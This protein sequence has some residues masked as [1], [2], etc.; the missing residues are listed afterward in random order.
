MKNLI[1]SVL[2]LMAVLMSTRGKMHWLRMINSSWR[3]DR[4]VWFCSPIRNILFTL[5][6]AEEIYTQVGE[7]ITLKPPV[8]KDLQKHYWYWS[9][10]DV[11]LAWSHPLGRK[12]ITAGEQC[13]ELS[14]Y[15]INMFL[16][17]T[18]ET[19]QN[20]KW[21][22][23]CNY[24]HLIIALQLEKHPGTTVCPCLTT[25]HW[26]L[27][28]SNKNTSGFLSVNT[29]WILNLSSSH[30]LTCSNSVVRVKIRWHDQFSHV[31]FTLIRFHLKQ[32]LLGL[33]REWTA[34][35]WLFKP[36]WTNS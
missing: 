19:G 4:T 8:I 6:G 13:I 7:T 34:T 3:G 24:N 26:P 11:L 14:T 10:G 9:F 2:I 22:I 16:P 12:E 29:G 1:K 15:I 28:T 35:F 25:T 5:L 30:Q 23:N 17:S 21:S 36:Q 32:Q 31:T 27:K 33:R 20:Y 18:D